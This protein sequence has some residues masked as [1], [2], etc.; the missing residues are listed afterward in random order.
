MAL[1]NLLPRT[2][3]ITGASC[4]GSDGDSNRTYTLP[5]SGTLSTGIDVVVSGTTLHEGA[6]L[7]FTLSGSTITFLNAMWD[8][9]AIRVNYFITFGAPSAPALSTSTDLKY[10]TPLMLAEMLGIMK[11]VPSWDIAA[12]PT[13]EAVGTGNGVLTSFYLDQKSIISDS[14]ALYANGS[15]M[16]ETTH[17]TLD[18]D[19]G[20]I[21]LT[22]AGVTLLG[23]NALTAKYKYYSNGMRDS[24]VI[25]VLSRA[26]KAVDGIINSTFT[27]GS[28][29]NPA[30]PIAIEF[31]PSE[32]RYMD[33]WITKNKPVVDVESQ[34]NGDI[35]NSQ[36]TLNLTSASG[37]EKF[38]TSGYIIVGSE[39][40]TYTGVTGDQLTGLSRGVLGTTAAVH[41]NGDAVHTSIVLFSNTDEGTAD[42][43]T[44]QP[45]GT[46]VNINEDGLIYRYKD[47]DP[48]PL[49][50]YGIAK[51]IEIIYLWGYNFVPAQVTRATLLQAKIMLMNDNVG[52]S[53]IA[54]RN[55]FQ[56]AQLNVD[57][58]ELNAVLNDYIILP[59][60][61]T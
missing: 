17:Y 29:T 30:Y 27:D 57:E 23:N 60:G 51:R 37:G 50:R 45:W 43:W 6:G 1:T 22:A 13:D 16:T 9:S 3:N 40:I 5:D 12:T 54:G 21:V 10:A 59:I 4:S 8:A 36:N 61:N 44:V 47:A 35:T 39:I 41:S 18:C 49:T 56:F 20:A 48:E 42:S 58:K 24:Y 26:E 14:Y 38:P 7:D 46:S 2:V 25:S 53:V 52:K 55:E 32:G 33:R 11:E 31:Q 15:A 19:T 34:L 28:T